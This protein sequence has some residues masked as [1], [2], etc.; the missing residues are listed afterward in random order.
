MEFLLPIA[1][2]ILWAVLVVA[3]L[4]PM[5]RPLRAQ[6]NS[7]PSSGSLSRIR[8]TMAIG[9]FGLCRQGR[10]PRH[11]YLSDPGPGDGREDRN[12]HRPKI[13]EV[14]RLRRRP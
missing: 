6:P 7:K 14:L 5:G 13:P 3:M 10:V 12:G 8:L 4:E 1:I 11:H 2:L 9:V